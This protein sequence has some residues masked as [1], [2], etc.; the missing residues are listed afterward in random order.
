MQKWKEIGYVPDSDDED[1]LRST[2]SQRSFH[3]TAGHQPSL[4]NAKLDTPGE[5]E[6]EHLKLSKISKE[7]TEDGCCNGHNT[8]VPYTYRCDKILD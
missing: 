7:E 4:R 2:Q 6:D 1:E 3:P 5:H 8:P